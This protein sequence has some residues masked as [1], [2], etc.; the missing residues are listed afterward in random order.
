MTLH[1]PAKECQ[2]WL[3]RQGEILAVFAEEADG[4]PLFFGRVDMVSARSFVGGATA[5]I[6]AHSCAASEKNVLHRRIFQKRG[7]IFGDILAAGRLGMKDCA[8][9][10]D[11]GLSRLP[12]AP[13]I[14]QNESNFDFI[15][16]MALATGRKFWVLDTME[17]HP[18]LAVKHCL[19]KTA[20]KFAEDK[21]VAAR[22]ITTPR[23][24]RFE[25]KSSEY[26]APGR[27]AIIPG[28]AEKYLVTEMRL[29]LEN[30]R[31]Q[32]SY[33]LEEFVEKDLEYDGREEN[34]TFLPGV[35]KD[36]DDPD[37]M[38]RVRFRVAPEYAEDEDDDREWL[39]WIT[40]YAGAKGGMAFVPE[41]G[42]A[43]HLMLVSGKGAAQGAA[44]EGALPEEAR[45]VANKYLGNN[46]GE[47]IIWKE[48]A[49]ELRSGESSIILTPENITISLG[50]GTITLDKKNLS[51]NVAGEME[52]KGEK[53]SLS[54]SETALAQAKSIELA[55]QDSIAASSREIALNASGT[56]KIGKKVELG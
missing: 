54:A 17:N 18:A 38:G 6:T 31:D 22:G 48:N 16:R 50:E 51:V 34:A 5:Q 30:E 52:M 10:I 13:I 19:D 35:V 29:T 14:F 8:L 28:V 9:E 40:P 23:G 49:L 21:I 32:Y 42:D 15:R 47:R 39:P 7:K 46:F 53:I 12:C 4:A 27:F 1:L 41:K 25:V 3:D 43:A 24:R 11:A 20:K 2:K 56:A 36:A 45:D 33:K 37:N 44:H 55:G 26:C